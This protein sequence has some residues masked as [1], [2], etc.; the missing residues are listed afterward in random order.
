[1]K[2]EWEEKDKNIGS[3]TCYLIFDDGKKVDIWVKDYTCQFEQEERKKNPRDWDYYN[4]HNFEVHF[5]NGFSMTE[6]FDA[7]EW[8]LEKVKLWAEDYLLDKLIERY[9]YALKELPQLEK[10]ALQAQE[11]K[12]LRRCKK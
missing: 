7:P 2:L 12:N 10:E 11:I 9:T 8:S 4:T 6:Y 3:Y 1:M 5:C